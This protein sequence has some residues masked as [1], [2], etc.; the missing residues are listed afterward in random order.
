MVSLYLV[1]AFVAGQPSW[2]TFEPAGAGFS[3]RL[4]GAAAEKKQTPAGKDKLQ[5]RVFVCEVEDGAYVVSVTDF[6]AAEGSVER[7][8]SNAR[9]GAVDSVQGKLLHE[10]KIKLGAHPGRELWIESAKA[11]MIHTR[12]Y[13]VGPRLYQT[14][15]IGP[16]KFVETKDTVRFLDSF[17]VSK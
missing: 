16:K 8:L 14:L 10:R 9:D 15:A 7:R 6:G 17:T 2:R 1:A 4:P 5:P 12:L 11:G 3:V 13:A